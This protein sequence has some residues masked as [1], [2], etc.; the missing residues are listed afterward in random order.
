MCR[1]GGGTR[2]GRD[3]MANEWLEQAF[4]DWL[5]RRGIDHRDLCCDAALRAEYRREVQRRAAL[6]TIRTDHEAVDVRG[7][8]LANWRRFFERDR[9]ML[10]KGW[11]AAVEVNGRPVT[12]T[13]VEVR[14][15]KDAP[16]GRYLCLA[17]SGAPTG[18][19]GGTAVHHLL[20]VRAVM[21]PAW[22]ADEAVPTFE[23]YVADRAACSFP[24]DRLAR[25]ERSG[26]V[27][28]CR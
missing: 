16:D 27:R 20:P 14:N 25:L 9:V 24:A 19:G 8:L 21:R 18:R 22:S 13:S 5:K 17:V 4:H 3:G 2:E 6:P 11:T 15:F 23:R 7:E 12:V 28:V 10:P 26:K 1:A